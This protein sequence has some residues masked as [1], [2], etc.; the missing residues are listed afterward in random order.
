[1]LQFYYFNIDTTQLPH[2]KRQLLKYILEDFQDVFPNELPR[3][4][5][6]L[7]NVDHQIELILNIVAV[8]IPPFSSYIAL[9]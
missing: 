4:L 1:M 2:Y 6:P 9:L 5:P 7:R 3:T 8:S